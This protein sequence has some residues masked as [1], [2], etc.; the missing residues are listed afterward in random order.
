MHFKNS[1]AY[2]GSISLA[3]SE[4]NITLGFMQELVPNQGDDWKFMLE[5]LDVIFDNLNQKKIKINK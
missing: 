5:Q 4:G 2:T 1:P 3:L